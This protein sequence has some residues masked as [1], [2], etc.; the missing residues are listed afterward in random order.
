ML[1]LCRA[2]SWTSHS[3]DFPLNVLEAFFGLYF[4]LSQAGAMLNNS[5]QQI[6]PT[7]RISALEIP[8]LGQIKTEAREWRLLG[9]TKQAEQ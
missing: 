8:D 4:V 3:S 1:D 2:S 9:T 6:S 7:N 5:F